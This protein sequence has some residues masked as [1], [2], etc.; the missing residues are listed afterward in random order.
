M[1]VFELVCYCIIYD[2][3]AMKGTKQQHHHQQ[4][5]SLKLT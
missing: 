5:H 2:A 3:N 1:A 4:Q